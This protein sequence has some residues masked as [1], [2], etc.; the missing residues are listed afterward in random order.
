MA[1]VIAIC[2]EKGGVGKTTSTYH[3]A[4][5]AVR[6]GAKVLCV[7]L[8]PQANLT[9]WVAGEP[10][11]PDQL[12]VADALS[13][14]AADVTLA[15]VLIE[16]RWNGLTLA[17]AVKTPLSR[18]RNELVMASVGRESRLRRLLDPVREDYDLV[19]I[20]G[21]PD[22]SLL[23]INA[24][25]AADAVVPPCAPA[26]LSLD[27]LAELMVTV[28]S[29]REHY[30]PDLQLGGVIINQVRR[31]RTSRD[32]EAEV[33]GSG[34]RVLTPSV[35]FRV[36]I[37]D[38]AESGARLEEWPGGYALADIYLTLLQQLIKEN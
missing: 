1:R 3:L 2:Q 20:D 14:L 12:S 4:A 8:D 15:D 37:Q 30:N 17:P 5:A 29:V 10:P 25:V 32:R 6:T 35:P 31:T 24:L 27:G 19:L 18:A 11:A 16:G 9:K 26:E 23:T 22:V 36:E 34:L 13:E 7:D 28:E 21:P 38:C 33:R